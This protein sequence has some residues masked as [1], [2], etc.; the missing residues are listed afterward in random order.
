MPP[1]FIIKRYF[2]DLASSQT[3]EKSAAGKTQGLVT[4]A[5]VESEQAIIATIRDAFPT[6]SISGRRKC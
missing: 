6:A 3:T 4:A 5:D 1:Q 2:A